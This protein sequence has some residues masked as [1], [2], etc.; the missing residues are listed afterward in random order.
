MDV[1]SKTARLA[2][3]VAVCGAVLL[4]SVASAPGAGAATE[5]NKSYVRALYGDILDRPDVTSDDAGITFWADRLDAPGQTRGSVV[6]GIQRS[7]TEYYGNI[8]D[9]NYALFLDRTAEPSGRSFYTDGFRS[10]RL[11]LEAIVVALGQSRE[12][13]IRVGGTNAAFVE[14]IYFDVLG[15]EADASGRAF[16]LDYV[17]TRGRGQYVALIQ[18]SNEKRRQVVRDTFGTFLGRQPTVTELNFWVGELAPGQTRREDFDGALAS[19]QEYYDRNSD[20]G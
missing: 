15:R 9:F 12:Y 3:A 16:A 17:A 4:G 1:R 8:V 5:A 11:T 2:A 20:G 10:R 6:M 14:A 19:S 7:G 18:R 13:F